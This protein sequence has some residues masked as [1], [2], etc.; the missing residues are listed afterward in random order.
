MLGARAP[1]VLVQELYA[2][3]TK[4]DIDADEWEV[5]IRGVHIKI[6][7]DILADCIGIQRRLSTYLAVKLAVVLPY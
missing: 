7:I 1:L 5:V 2:A 6:F 4:I 3:L